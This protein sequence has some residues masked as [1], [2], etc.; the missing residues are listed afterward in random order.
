MPPR[1]AMTTRPI[2]PTSASPRTI[3][4]VHATV[5]LTETDRTTVDTEMA[6]AEKFETVDGYIAS[7]PDDVQKVLRK[8]RATIRKA[9]PKAEEKISYQ[10]PTFALDGRYL[11]YFAGWKN[12][13]SV[14]PLPEADEAFERELAPYKSGKG[15]VKFPLNKPIP[16]DLIGRLAALLAE[17]RR[18]AR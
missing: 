15:T 8:V 7:F 9:V 12:H 1:T 3:E 13:I 2:R 14:Y 10:I 4:I 11:V 17:Q 5:E 18:S 16:Y 6:M